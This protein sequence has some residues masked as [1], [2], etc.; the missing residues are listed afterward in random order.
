VEGNPSYSVDP[1]GLKRKNVNLGLGYLGAID[2]FDVDGQASFQIHVFDKKN[3]EVGLY[4]PDGW[5]NKHGKTGRPDG[6]PDSVE[7]QCKGHATDIGRRLGK[8][9][10]IGRGD[11]SG[12]KWKKFFSKVPVL[13]PLM[14]MTRPSIER[15]C[16]LNPNAEIC[17]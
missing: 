17:Q 10:P 15:A 6:L 1:S 16:E 11:I 13:G 2:T 9:P 3:N 12:D 5:F 4:G 14:E 8:I 7:A